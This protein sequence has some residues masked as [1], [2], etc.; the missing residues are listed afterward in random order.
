MLEKKQGVILVSKLRAILLM[1]ADFSFASKTIFGRHM[2][3][4]AEDRNDI[5]GECASS[6]QHHEATD[7]ALNR[8]APLAGLTSSSPSTLV[9]T[10]CLLA[11]LQTHSSL[12]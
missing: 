10:H 11:T 3:H 1:E 12:L 5:A 6:H 9:P 4:F 2:M 8:D 7:V